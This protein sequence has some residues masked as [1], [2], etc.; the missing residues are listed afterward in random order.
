M[1]SWTFKFNWG[2]NRAKL[3]ENPFDVTQCP[4][5]ETFHKPRLSGGCESRGNAD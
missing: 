4:E 1:L 5:Q 3:E 2:P